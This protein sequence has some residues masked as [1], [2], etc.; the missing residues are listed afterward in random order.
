LVA[1][2]AVVAAVGSYA[3]VLDSGGD[4][5]GDSSDETA[6]TALVRVH[7]TITSGGVAV[8][9]RLATAAEDGP[10]EYHLRIS[11]TA[12]GRSWRV[13]PDPPKRDSHETTYETAERRVG[14]AVGAGRIRPGDLRVEV[15]Q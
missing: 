3:V 6:E 7:E 13:G 2:A 4:A 9:A 12:A 1:A 10:A 15:W 5:G 14:V 8:P 11:L